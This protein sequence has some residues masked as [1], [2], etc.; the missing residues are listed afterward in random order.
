MNRFSLSLLIVATG[1]STFLA[2][3]WSGQSSSAGAKESRRV[4]YYVDPMNPAHT[5]SKPGFAPCG[6]KLE[7]VYADAETAA[8]ESGAKSETPG[9]SKASCC[10]KKQVSMLKLSSE[11]MQMIGVQVGAVE[12]MD[13][14]R[15]VRAFGRVKPDDRKIYHI[16]SGIEGTV[17]EVMGI[18]VGSHV[19]KGECLGTFRAPD[20]RTTILGY[21]TAV[22]IVDRSI[23]S[24]ATN[25]S[26]LTIVRENVRLAADRL[27][28]LS[29]SQGQIEEINQSRSVPSTLRIVAPSDGVVIASS[30]SP[31]SKFEKNHEW[32][33]IADLSRVWVVADVSPADANG[34]TPGAEVEIAVADAGEQGTLKGRI[35][36]SLPQYDPATRTHKVRIEV[37]NPRFALRPEMLVDVKL[38][39]AMPK[40]L[41]VSEDS[42]LRSGVTATVFVE[43]S[44]GTFVPKQ[45]EVGR[46]FDNRIEILS[47]L[48][49]GDRIAT[50]GLFLLDSESRMKQSAMASASTTL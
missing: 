33:R 29:I 18:A 23:A 1:V 4:L 46:K 5:S 12:R 3:G 15:T 19:K 7:P 45:V 8:A 40:S 21:L 22:D 30:I 26:Q 37:E 9:Q 35:S 13:G 24:G 20:T 11:K 32:Y 50:S 41:A 10:E 48:S 25:D 2:G 36:E 31:A 42:L 38:S 14:H 6:M 17:Q 43:K 34:F 49:E 47:G 39:V 44:A 28:G 16:Y 27:I